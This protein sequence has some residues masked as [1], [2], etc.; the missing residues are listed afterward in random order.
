M[1]HDEMVCHYC[2]Y[3]TNVPVQC[4]QCGSARLRTVG[5]GTEK[6]EDDL[7]LL[8]P[9]ALVQRMDLDST[10]S[11]QS[12]QKILD[13]FSAGTIDFLVGTQMVT[14]GLDFDN[15]RLV[16]ILDADRMI[17]FPDFRSVERAFQMMVQVSGRAGRREERGMVIIQTASPEHR[18]IEKVIR[19]DFTRMVEEEI[20]E[21]GKFGYPPFTR[22]IRITAKHPD[23]DHSRILSSQIAGLIR[24]ALGEKRV[25]GPEENMI[26]RIRNEYWFNIL[27][28]L[29]REGVNLSGAKEVIKTAALSVF[30]NKI[31]RKGR[32][33][34]DVDPY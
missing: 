20:T 7:K 9:E 24:D 23:R 16:G 5:F 18:L 31:F 25:L 17:N 30:E 19:N 11:K 34:F 32:I 4:E 2:G 10:R 8:I 28:K 1:H 12:Y 29:E 6:I 33:T 27:V 14:K 3:K 13:R 22:L 15:V 26:P 21:R